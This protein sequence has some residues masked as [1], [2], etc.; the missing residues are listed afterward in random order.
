MVE[1]YVELGERRYPIHM[2]AELPG[3]LLVCEVARLRPAPAP[4]LIVTDDNVG[5]LY[6]DGV[7]QALKAAGYQP[8]CLTLAHGEASKTLNVVSK[9]LD[10]A[11][12][13]G[14]SRQDLIVALGGGVVGDIAGFSASVLLRGVRYIQV[15]TTL[16]AQVDSAVGGK[17]GVN[18]KMG[19]NLIGAFWQPS[20]VISSQAVLST[21]PDRERRCGLAEA[22]KHG[23]LGDAS[24]VTWCEQH[25]QALRT[26]EPE[27]VAHLVERCCTIKGQVVSDDERE[28]GRRAVLNLGH[29]FGHAYERLMGYGTLTHGEAVAL[30]MVWSARL[31]ERLGVAEPGL[32]RVLVDIFESLGLPNDTQGQGLPSLSSLMEAAR[33]DKK[34]DQTHVTF[35][36]IEEVGRTLFKRLPWT[37][38]EEALSGLPSRRTP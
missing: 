17:T 31:S 29:T 18:H 25:A 37:H 20:A 34:A 10:E 19:K 35:I 8:H 3:R 28:S 16:L 33:N 4:I 7:C 11:L 23:I 1:L 22:I 21:L 12:S 13:L 26:L 5:A 14:L 6:A 27:A 15:P 9:V 2:T 36:L 30:G 38:I 24:L 32:E